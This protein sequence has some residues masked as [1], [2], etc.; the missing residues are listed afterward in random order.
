MKVA[1]AAKK[2]KI[3]DGIEQIKNMF[4]DLRNKEPKFSK[5]TVQLDKAHKTTSLNGFLDTLD[6]KY[7]KLNVQQT[8][9]EKMQM[10]AINRNNAKF[11][12]T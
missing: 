12:D 8:N 11:L 4:M 7:K 5:I 6:Q 3:K 10:E 9:M 1:N 2:E